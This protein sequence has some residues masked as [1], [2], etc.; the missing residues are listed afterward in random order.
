MLQGSS[1]HGAMQS[2]LEEAT[3][4]EVPDLCLALQMCSCLPTT[5]S[6][7]ASVWLYSL[8]CHCAAADSDGWPTVAKI[9]ALCKARTSVQISPAHRKGCEHHHAGTRKDVMVSL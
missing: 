1:W 7:T 6:Q 2:R 3:M 9:R 5:Q 4:T 8:S